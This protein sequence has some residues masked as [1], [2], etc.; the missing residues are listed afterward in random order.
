MNISDGNKFTMVIPADPVVKKENGDAVGADDDDKKSSDSPKENKKSEENTVGIKVNNSL[1]GEYFTYCLCVQ[2]LYNFSENELRR[3]VSMNHFRYWNADH[4][5]Y[6]RAK[7]ADLKTEL[8]SNTIRKID[9]RGMRMVA[10]KSNYPAILLI[11]VNPIGCLHRFFRVIQ[12]GK[13][14]F[15]MLCMMYRLHCCSLH[16]CY[17]MPS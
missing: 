14:H 9:Q 8:L 1:F 12:Q 2:I 16:L 15:G 13:G 17:L 10:I 3:M 11:A 5:L 7:Y 6:S 4:S